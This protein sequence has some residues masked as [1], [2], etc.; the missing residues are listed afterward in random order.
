MNSIEKQFHTTQYGEIRRPI[1][2]CP[3]RPMKKKTGK[4]FNSGTPNIR[5]YRL[6]IL[7]QRNKCILTLSISV[8]A[9]SSFRTLGTSTDSGET[10]GTATASEDDPEFDSERFR[11]NFVDLIMTAR[12]PVEAVKTFE[13]A[14]SLTLAAFNESLV[15]KAEASL[16]SVLMLESRVLMV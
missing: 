12:L 10:I 13:L 4:L 5:L 14:E 8:A 16:F 2:T 3:T 6:F 1:Y 7:F 15:A 9:W 11:T